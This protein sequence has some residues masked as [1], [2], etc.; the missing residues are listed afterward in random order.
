MGKK[1]TP[2]QELLVARVAN[3]WIEY[4]GQLATMRALI[5]MKIR[6]QFET[7]M[8]RHRLKVAMAVQAALDEG[9][10][11][12]ALREVTSKDPKTLE[13]FLAELEPQTSASASMSA[14]LAPPINVGLETE[15][16]GDDVYR[17]SIDP[18]KVEEGYY[19]RADTEKWSGL[20][21]VRH[22]DSGAYL[23]PVDDDLD[24]PGAGVAEWLRMGNHEQQVLAKLGIA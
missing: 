22:G 1:P 9:C 5:E 13:K 16:A 8:K 21:D 3:T 2:E 14:P 6:N 19:K 7:E 15:P 23:E 4:K 12:K 20:F 11:K 17:I 10:T 18:S 24:A